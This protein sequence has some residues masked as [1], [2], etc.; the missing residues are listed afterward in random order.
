MSDLPEYDEWGEAKKVIRGY[1]GYDEP[2]PTP[3]LKEQLAEIFVPLLIWL[4]VLF[5][6]MI[7]SGTTIEIN[8]RH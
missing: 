6:L 8:P 3:P 2:K 7:F 4:A 5:L 1:Y